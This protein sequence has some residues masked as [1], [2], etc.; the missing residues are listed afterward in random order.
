MLIDLTHTFDYPMPVYPGDPEYH[1]SFSRE[2]GKDGYTISQVSMGMHTGTHVDSP[3][4]MIKDGMG[5]SV[6]PVERFRGRGVLI[7]ARA[8]M[9]IDED[10][11]DKVT[12]SR[13]DIVLVLTGWNES[14]GDESY[15]RD[16]PKITHAFAKALVQAEVGM[17]GS[18][19]PGPDGPPFEIHRM[20]L[21]ARI[22]IIEN[23]TN[24]ELLLDH[25]HFEV[26]ALPAKFNAEAAPARVVAIAS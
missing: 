16:Y 1:I 9:I 2:E 20:L 17:V 3:L 7:D 18:D 13:N 5:I 19:T 22:F 14:F 15:F 24:L 12:L 26:I 6:I 23:L 25:P 4:H 11:L 10:L 8:R 21:S